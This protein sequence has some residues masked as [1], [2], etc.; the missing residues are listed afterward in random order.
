MIY[1]DGISDG[2]FDKAD[3]EIEMTREA[4]KSMTDVSCTCKRE[5]NH[6]NPSSTVNQP[7]HARPSVVVREARYYKDL[8]DTYMASK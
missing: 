7:Q 1:R 8:L 4:V 6:D 5:P 2:N 3:D